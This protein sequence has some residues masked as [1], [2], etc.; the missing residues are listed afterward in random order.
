MKLITTLFVWCSMMLLASTAQATTD[1]AA[2]A[3]YPVDV[4]VV[5]GEAD[6]N[7]FLSVIG[8]IKDKID[9]SVEK[10]DSVQ[11]IRHGWYHTEL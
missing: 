2:G 1:A 3:I 9:T 5:G 10:T 7:Q 6:G 8:Q 11:N 4:Q